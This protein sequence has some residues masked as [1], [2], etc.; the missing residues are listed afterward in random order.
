MDIAKTLQ[1]RPA[2]QTCGLVDFDTAE[3]FVG[4]GG[5]GKFLLVT[6][7]RA[8]VSM[9]VD[10]RPLVY[11]TQ[12]DYWGIEVVGCVSGIVLPQ[13]AP[14]AETLE[15]SAVAGTK[16]IE[17]IGAGESRRIDL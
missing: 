16:G 8:T 1:A 14:Y 11:V 17:V 3:V 15:I 10:L 5:N 4:L 7:E 6:G 13:T 12:P 9:R 2:S